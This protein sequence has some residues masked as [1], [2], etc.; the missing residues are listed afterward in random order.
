MGA[1]I[2]LSA[3]DEHFDRQWRESMGTY[4]QRAKRSKNGQGNWR[5]IRY[6]AG[7]F[8]IVVARWAAARR[9]AA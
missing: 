4:R 1:N 7:H 3:L 8:V 9:G 2:A 6:A 5:F